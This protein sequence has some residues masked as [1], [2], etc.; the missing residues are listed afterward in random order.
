MPA[1]QATRQELV[2]V[3]TRWMGLWRGGDLAGFDELHAPGFVDNSAAGRARDRDGLRAG[4]IELYEAFPDFEANIEQLVVDVEHSTVAIRWTASG[5]HRGLFLTAAPS[6][7][8]IR[9][10]GIEI[11]EIAEG[12]VVARWGEWDGLDL[13]AQLSPG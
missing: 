12:R 2:E 7:R 4:I 9:F 11:I 10:A 6:H 13:V 5:T 3:A 8:S 1:R